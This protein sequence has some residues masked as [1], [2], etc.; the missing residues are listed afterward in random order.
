MS[1]VN[2]RRSHHYNASRNRPCSL[3]ICSDGWTYK[4]VLAADYFL[5][6]VP[7]DCFVIHTM[8]LSVQNQITACKQ[9]CRILFMKQW[10]CFKFRNSGVVV[11]YSTDPLTLSHLGQVIQNHTLTRLHAIMVYHWNDPKYSP[12]ESINS[13]VC[14]FIT[15][16]H[17]HKYKYFTCSWW[18]SF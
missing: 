4:C 17:S 2:Q 5:D 18:S 10:K 14:L 7:Q 6:Q 1:P 13:I 3:Y 12:T 16:F 9:S 11:I 8:S 15:C